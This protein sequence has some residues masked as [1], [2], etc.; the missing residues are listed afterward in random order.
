MFVGRVMYM[1]S[2]KRVITSEGA[3]AWKE[4]LDELRKT[5]PVDPLKWNDAMALAAYD[6]CNDVGKKGIESHK[7]SDGSTPFQRLARY[8]AA[9]GFQGE[10]IDF[11]NTSP[12]DI[13]MSLYIDD[14]VANRSHRDAIMDTTFKVTSIAFCKHNSSSQQMVDIVYAGSMVA[15]DFAKQRVKELH[16]ARGSKVR[17][18]KKPKLTESTSNTVQPK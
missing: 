17:I 3:S 8:G 2:G 9:G 14:G 7:G 13:V 6:H 1:D 5:K 16:R 18:T 15:N 10:N 11:G 4:A 12:I